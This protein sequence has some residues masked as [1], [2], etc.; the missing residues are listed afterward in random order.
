MANPESR[1]TVFDFYCNSFEEMPAK[2]EEQVGYRVEP[3]HIWSID[4]QQFEITKLH[5]TLCIIYW[6]AS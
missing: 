6:K 1:I 4:I 5:V 2:M 3:R